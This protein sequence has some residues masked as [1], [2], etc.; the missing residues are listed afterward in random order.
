MLPRFQSAI[1]ESG[2]TVKEEDRFKTFWSRKPGFGLPVRTQPVRDWLD[3]VRARSLDR[4]GRRSPLFE[5][6]RPG[7]HED[8]IGRDGV[9]GG[10]GPGMHL[11]PRA[12]NGI[13]GRAVPPATWAVSARFNFRGVR[14]SF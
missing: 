12:G 1:Q 11:W 14:R 3:A 5:V 8:L 9:G 6:R 2:L 4:L 7:R 10:A 13:R